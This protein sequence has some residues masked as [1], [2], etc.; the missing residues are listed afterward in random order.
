MCGTSTR[1]VKGMERFSAGGPRAAAWEQVVKA[2]AGAELQALR[3]EEENLASPSPF[4]TFFGSLMAHSGG[5]K[6]E[7]RGDHVLTPGRFK[8][9]GEGIYER[10]ISLAIS[11]AR[12]KKTIGSSERP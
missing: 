6:Q 12:G 2:G 1:D 5:S 4:L 8:L 7:S 11:S 9:T 3:G 10:R